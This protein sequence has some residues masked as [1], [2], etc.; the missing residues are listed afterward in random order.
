MGEQMRK[1]PASFLLG[2]CLLFTNPLAHAEEFSVRSIM[3]HLVSP[4]TEGRRPGSADHDQVRDYLIS[5]LKDLGFTPAGDTEVGERKFTQQFLGY[6]SSHV[7]MPGFTTRGRNI[8]AIFNPP[9]RE[10]TN[11]RLLMSAHYDHLGID[12]V[13]PKVR[14]GAVNSDHHPVCPGA[15]DNAGGVAALLA[16]LPAL[17]QQAQQP[18]AVAFWDFE[19]YNFQGSKSFAENPTFPMDDLRVILNL[20]IIGLDLFPTTKTWSF[21]IGAETGGSELQELMKEGAKKQG[22]RLT[23]HFFSYVFGHDRND[24]TNFFE[25]GYK[26]PTVLLSDAD[27]SVYHS[28]ADT[29]ENFNFAKAET[30]R[31][32]LIEVAPKVLAREEKFS[33]SSPSG[34]LGQPHP[35]GKDA[36]TLIR[37]I[38]DTLTHKSLPLNQEEKNKLEKILYDTSFLRWTSY[39]FMTPSQMHA[40]GGHIATFLQVSQSLFNRQPQ[41]WKNH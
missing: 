13:T 7:K 21:I 18:F 23:E 6:A 28:N 19:E 14:G 1:I 38:K 2:A 36:R 16:A 35:S 29:L 24:N 30:I 37:L 33:Y 26:I 40:L 3:P 5:H 12:C 22:S 25:K 27:G 31:D 15:A 41:L 4:A 11:P 39:A 17:T 32:L 34:W 9:G 10:S 8:I 20:D